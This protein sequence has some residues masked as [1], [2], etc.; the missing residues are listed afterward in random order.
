[1]PSIHDASILSMQ[2]VHIVGLSE[3][4]DG[5]EHMKGV[6]ALKHKEC[7]TEDALS[8]SKVN[9]SK[10]FQICEFLNIFFTTTKY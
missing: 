9:L 7:G 3:S 4:S 2:F 1:M 10:S 8:R 6:G 5:Q